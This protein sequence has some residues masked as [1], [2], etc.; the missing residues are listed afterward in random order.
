MGACALADGGT[1]RFLPKDYGMAM[2]QHMTSS[3]TISNVEAE[4]RQDARS[5]QQLAMQ[6]SVAASK[7]AA[8]DRVCPWTVE[9]LHK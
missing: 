4:W 9:I 6:H 7:V 3:S 5:E 1:C 8:I 2:V